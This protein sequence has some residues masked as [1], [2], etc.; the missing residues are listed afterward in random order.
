MNNYFVTLGLQYAHEPHPYLPRHMAQPGG[1]LLVQAE[2][3]NRARDAVYA[4]IGT[5]YAFLYTQD[6]FDGTLHPLG[7]LGIL[8][9]GAYP[10]LPENAEPG[11]AEIR[12][13]A[14]ERLRAM[15]MYDDDGSV[16]DLVERINDYVDREVRELVRALRSK[17]GA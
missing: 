2:D 7:C 11:D 9:H 15:V 13:Y 5:A 17:D 14:T 4:V 16:N 6:E 12:T 10:I 3:E 8:K 1:Y